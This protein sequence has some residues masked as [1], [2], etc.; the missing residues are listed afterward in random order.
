MSC[1][2][3]SLP[4]R[5]KLIRQFVRTHREALFV[6]AIDVLGGPNANSKLVS[7]MGTA[8]RRVPSVAIVR[9]GRERPWKTISALYAI[10]ACVL[11]EVSR[12]SCCTCSRYHGNGNV[13]DAADTDRSWLASDRNTTMC[14]PPQQRF[15]S[16]GHIRSLSYASVSEDD[17]S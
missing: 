14:T 16:A 4:Y 7:L 3:K 17:F 8:P 6:A 15:W 9:I 5:P 2:L 13:Y 11:L 1:R 12:L 10:M